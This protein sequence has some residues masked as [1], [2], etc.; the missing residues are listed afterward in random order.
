V[1]LPGIGIIM[2]SMVLASTFPSLWK[3]YRVVFLALFVLI[4]GIL[5]FAAFGAN[6]RGVVDKRAAE[7]DLCNA[8]TQGTGTM[9]A[10]FGLKPT[11]AGQSRPAMIDTG[12]FYG[13]DNMLSPAM[14]ARKI[15]EMQKHPEQKLLLPEKFDGVCIVNAE[16]QRRF[17]EVLFVYPFHKKAEHLDSVGEPLCTYIQDHYHRTKN[18][19]EHGYQVWSPNANPIP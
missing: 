11:C 3:T 7:I 2:I 17:L 8:L 4:P 6:Q 18:L 13:V 15:G 9:L 12:Y 19:G 14:V 1:K 10:P 16:L 5:D